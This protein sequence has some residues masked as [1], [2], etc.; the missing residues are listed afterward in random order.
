LYLKDLSKVI[1]VLSVRY[2]E[3]YD[4][5]RKLEARFQLP[6]IVISSA[7]GLTAFGTNQF[8]ASAQRAI[9]LSMGV[10]GLG[11]GIL[12]SIQSYLKI[13]TTMSGCLLASSNLAKLKESIDLEL[14]L[15]IDD[16]SNSGLVYLRS[17]C[18]DYET[19]V[20]AAPPVLKRMRF[21]KPLGGVLIE[22]SD[23]G[24]APSMP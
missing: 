15:S 14:S 1:E 4:H 17:V 11:L 5:Y 3:E 12:N 7:I 19:I 6:A 23:L 9:N 24:E 16:R 18:G 10:V 13:G 21:V 2:K 20:S 22:R 8:E